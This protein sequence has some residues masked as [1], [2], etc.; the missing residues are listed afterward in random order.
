MYDFSRRGRKESGEAQADLHVER[1]VHVPA[2]GR[3]VGVAHVLGLGD[4]AHVG[5]SVT[6]VVPGVT[7]LHRALV[8]LNVTEGKF[9]YRYMVH[10]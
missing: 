6:A 4:L 5:E 2:L 7:S 1:S 10:K 3:G 8:A 9:S